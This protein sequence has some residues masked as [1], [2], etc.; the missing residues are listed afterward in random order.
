MD[1]FLFPAAGQTLQQAI[2][3]HGAVW[4]F[5]VEA[6]ALAHAA[7]GRERDLTATFVPGIPKVRRVRNDINDDAWRFLRSVADP[8]IT[9]GLIR[10]FDT[11]EGGDV[12]ILPDGMHVRIKKGDIDGSTSNYPTRR[13]RMMGVASEQLGLF[14]GATALDLAIQDGV[15]FDVVFVAGEA[16]GSYTHVGLRLAVTDASPFMVLDPAT[17]KQLRAISPA[18]FDL[19]ADARKKLAS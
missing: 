10:S 3:R 1:E 5:A 7:Y 9:A 4:P 14:S 6:V 2:A 8:L 15:V 16:L 12:M 18:A 11:V 13:V 19:V 17:E